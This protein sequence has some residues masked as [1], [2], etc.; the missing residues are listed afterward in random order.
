MADRHREEVD[1]VG[2]RDVE[3]L[4]ALPQSRDKGSSYCSRPC[5]RRTKSDLSMRLT[6]WWACI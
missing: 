1:Q 6:P 3:S 2:A 5:R 4:D